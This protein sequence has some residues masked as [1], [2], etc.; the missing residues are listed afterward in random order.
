MGIFMNI[1][2]GCSNVVKYRA[3]ITGILHENIRILVI[4]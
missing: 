1:Y 2:G 3:N 4:V